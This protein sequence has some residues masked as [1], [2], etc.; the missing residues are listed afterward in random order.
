MLRFPIALLTLS[1]ALGACDVDPCGSTAEAFAQR[2]GDFF[3]EAEA[4]DHDASAPAWD[5]YDERL[6]LLVEDCYPRHEADLSRERERAFWRGVSAYYVHRFGRAG[7]REA[8]R[9]LRGA[10]NGL[11]GWLDDNL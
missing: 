6:R 8:L 4:A 1:L 2:A 9:E 7:A 3:A 11:E 5:L 10:L